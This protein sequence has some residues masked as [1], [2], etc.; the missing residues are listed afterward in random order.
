MGK[1]QALR[2]DALPGGPQYRDWSPL[3][4]GPRPRPARN[5][6]SSSEGACRKQ[7]GRSPSTL[8]DPRPMS[9]GTDSRLVLSHSRLVF[10]QSAV[11]G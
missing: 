3:E 7:K 1:R 2:A 5:L 8:Q 4:E 6:T 11:A 10:S 9:V